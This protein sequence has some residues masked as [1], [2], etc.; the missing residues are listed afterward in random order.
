M[1]K[2]MRFF[3]GMLLLCVVGIIVYFYLSAYEQQKAEKEK[4][5]YWNELVAK[6]PK[7]K[8]ISQEDF[9]AKNK[10][11]YC[12]R[13]EKYY[14]KEELKVKAMVSLIEKR[15]Q[16]VE[17]FKKGK[18]INRMQE[19]VIGGTAAFCGKNN[20]GIWFSPIKLSKS[21]MQSKLN[22][23]KL[24][25]P[26]PEAVIEQFFSLKINKSED[27]ENYFK[28]YGS[29]N[30]VLFERPFHSVVF[31]S[32]CCSILDENEFKGMHDKFNMTNRVDNLPENIGG[33]PEGY[34]LKYYRLY[35]HYLVSEYF[36]YSFLPYEYDLD[37]YSEKVIYLISNC[38]DVLYSPYYYYKAY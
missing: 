33:I 11:G 31:T 13:D 3:T 7:P 18:A 8:N 16:I 19:E 34:N 9:I 25:N 26:Y 5:R 2:T 14:T 4:Y 24:E 30:Y 35:N 10:E 22:L 23:I 36:W 27:L 29:R 38:G 37:F 20:C 1:N 28:T 6:N 15:L 17:L 21:E 32:D 12:W